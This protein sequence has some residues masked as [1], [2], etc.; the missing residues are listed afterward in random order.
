MLRSK[1]S[2]KYEIPREMK[3]VENSTQRATFGYIKIMFFFPKVVTKK[4]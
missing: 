1:N 2:A 3:T 4:H